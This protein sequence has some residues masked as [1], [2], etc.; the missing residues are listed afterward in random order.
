ML[1]T[2]LDQG[3]VRG[4][5]T[6]GLGQGRWIGPVSKIS[7]RGMSACASRSMHDLEHCVRCENL[8]WLSQPEKHREKRKK[9]D[10]HQHDGGQKCGRSMRL[11][12]ES[13]C[14]AKLRLPQVIHALAVLP[15]RDH[16]R[17]NAN[18]D[19]GQA[20]H[21][22]RPGLTGRSGAPGIVENRWKN[23]TMVKPKLISET[24]VRIQAMNVRSRAWRVLN[25][26]KWLLADASIG[27]R[28][29]L[30]NGRTR[31]A[32]KAQPA[33]LCGLSTAQAQGRWK[34]S[35]SGLCGKARISCQDR[36]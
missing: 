13:G 28:C 27:K 14:G 26:A 20:Q 7:L 29:E 16:Q 1:D 18:A 19:Q 12:A 31:Y 24:A 33:W 10:Q 35:A 30:L 21:T 9:P 22:R 8:D 34:K 23:C 4:A 3:P 2:R 17:Q 36:T 11:F 15:A 5:R 6:I 32:G 25:Q